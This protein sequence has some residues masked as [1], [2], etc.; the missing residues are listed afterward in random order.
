V[1]E[2]F[3]L[4]VTLHARVRVFNGPETID[5]EHVRA[6]LHEYLTEWSEGRYPFASEMVRRGLGDTVEAA[7]YDAATKAGLSEYTQDLGATVQ[8]LRVISLDHASVVPSDG[9][10]VLRRFNR[11]PA[12]SIRAGRYVWFL[13]AV[14]TKHNHGLGSPWTL[15]IEAMEGRGTE[16]TF[17]TMKAAEA[18]AARAWTELTEAQRQACIEQLTKGAEDK[19]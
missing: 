6:E 17:P 4:D 11:V 7:V 16:P 5:A 19:T 3:D 14:T 13:D 8:S 10:A 12:D 18:A 15:K 2:F 1:S 9:L